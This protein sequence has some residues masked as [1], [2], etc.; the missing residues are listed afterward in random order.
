MVR[1]GRSVSVVSNGPALVIT[2][3][4]T[5]QE[6]ETFLMRL[7]LCA[8]LACAAGAFQAAMS[9]ARAAVS[10]RASAA[11]MKHP[12][13]YKRIAKAEAG[14]LRLCVTRCGLCP[15]CLP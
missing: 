11:T 5:S 1:L 12:D 13:Y 9:P 2:V 10:S 7:L 15:G 3:F 4:L 6:I 14:R 8:S